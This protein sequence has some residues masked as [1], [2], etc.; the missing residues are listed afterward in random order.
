[1]AHASKRS[2][3][4]KVERRVGVVVGTTV[5]EVN[6]Q[7]TSTKHCFCHVPFS[8]RE[9]EVAHASKRSGGAKVECRVGVVVGTT[10]L[11]VTKQ[12]TSTEKWVCRVPGVLRDVS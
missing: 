10:V 1:M 3:G 11:E 6:K 7:M 5:L 8:G 12:T 9:G 2:G 4:T